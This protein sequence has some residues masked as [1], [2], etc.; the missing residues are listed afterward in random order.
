MTQVADQRWNSKYQKISWV[1]ILM[2]GQTEWLA[3]PHTLCPDWG[4][5]VSY[6]TVPA[7]PVLDSPPEVD[8]VPGFCPPRDWTNNHKVINPTPTPIKPRWLWW[9]QFKCVYIYPWTCENVIG[10]E[11]FK[12]QK[13]DPPRNRT[14]VCRVIHGE[15]TTRLVVHI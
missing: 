1:I 4:S 15:H 11:N 12:F 5:I 7:W 8:Q 9:F 6:S 13:I 3:M 10:I 14:E 2:T